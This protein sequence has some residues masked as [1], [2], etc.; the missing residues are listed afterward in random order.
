MSHARTV[1]TSAVNRPSLLR[2]SAWL[3]MVAAAAPVA[4]QV[5][6]WQAGVVQSFSRD[7]NVG[8]AA[9]GSDTVSD[10]VS[11]TGL[12]LGL[13][14]TIG[15]QRLQGN[16]SLDANRYAR[17]KQLNNES[18]E[19]GSRL[20]W[21]SL[22]R[23][24]GVMTLGARQALYR[25][26]NAVNLNSRTMLRSTYGGIQNQL[27]IVT[28]LSFDGGL[29]FSRDRYSTTALSTRDLNQWSANLGLRLRPASGLQLR[30]G[31]R[32]G[33]GRYVNATDRLKR[34]DLDLSA[35][36]ELSG[37]SSVNT[38]LSR[39]VERHSLAGVADNRGWTG[40]VAWDWKPTGQLK[41]NLGLTRDGSVAAAG[42]DNL[43]TTG[44][45]TDTRV[46]NRLHARLDWDAAA[47][48]KAYANLGVT[49]RT[50]DGSV[51]LGNQA[52]AARQSD[53][54]VSTGLGLNYTPM[55]NLEFSCGL[56]REDRHADPSTGAQLT[57]A[58][59]VTV[60]SCSGA[61]YLR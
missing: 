41:F 49:S 53:R 46:Q 44:A 13:D 16:L 11:G 30:A 57:Y 22:E 35:A 25:A 33:E 3:V 48:W 27:G 15:R 10:T 56:N 4:A 42:F 31:L 45:S 34:D 24:A 14:Q 20:D 21:S 38:R 17:T 18:Y 1:R 52:A 37:L 61:I 28:D 54:T 9:K 60:L 19:L 40:G 39:T 59:A 36:M 58:Y 2:G 8:R 50:L 32:H 29:S 43:V 26:D 51:V 23:V 47:A 12:R 5:S 6:P 55:R 7:S